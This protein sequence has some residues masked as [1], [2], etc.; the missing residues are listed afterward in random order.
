MRHFCHL[1]QATGR[2]YVLAVQH[3]RGP[4]N[5]T[6]RRQQMAHFLQDPRML[7]PSTGALRLVIPRRVSSEVGEQT[8]SITSPT[9]SMLCR[10]PPHLSRVSQQ[11]EF[12]SAFC[13]LI[14]M[15]ISQF[16]TSTGIV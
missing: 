9:A 3:E 11:F 14:I 2:I 1:L 12:N 10:T 13:N 15:R 5:T 16:R 8:V 6:L 4:R 7:A